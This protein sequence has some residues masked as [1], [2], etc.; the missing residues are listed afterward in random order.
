MT[1]DVYVTE[2]RVREKEELWLPLAFVIH[3]GMCNSYHKCGM[4]N[5]FCECCGR[6]W[7]TLTM[8]LIVCGL[9]FISLGIN[10]SNKV[11]LNSQHC[12]V[13]LHVMDVLWL[14][15]LSLLLL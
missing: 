7:C 8:I 15:V 6:D 13:S 11:M 1:L 2:D 12:C 10:V 9:L 5:Y 4:C 14:R 3:V